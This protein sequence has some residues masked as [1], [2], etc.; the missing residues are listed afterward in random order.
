MED[1]DDLLEN[2]YSRVK[3]AET[4]EELSSG[5]NGNGSSNNGG[6]ETSV[7]KPMHDMLM[8]EARK[9]GIGRG[10]GAGRRDRSRDSRDPRDSASPGGGDRS[11]SGR[12]GRKS[13]RSG[14]H[15]SGRSAEVGKG[16]SDRGGKDEGDGRKR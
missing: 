14:S 8:S 12:G 3:G 6:A 16:R 4:G 5:E 7:T 1:V 10:E 9:A 15:E 2:A 11:R 13:S